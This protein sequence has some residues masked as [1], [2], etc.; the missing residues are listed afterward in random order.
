MNLN[1]HCQKYTGNTYY[2][3]RRI[4]FMTTPFANA[5]F[6]SNE[7]NSNAVLLLHAYTGSP[8]DVNMLARLLNRHGYNVLAP[9]FEGHREEDIF[10][11]LKARPHQW[12]A[13]TRQWLEWLNQEGYDKI[14]VFGL[15]MGGVFAT[16]AMTQEEFNIVSGGVF[17]SPVVTKH[18]INIERPFM[19]YAKL[20]YQDAGYDDFDQVSQEIVEKHR[21]Q[22]QS[23]ETFKSD[24]L[25]DLS[26]IQQPFYIA[27]SGQDELINPDDAKN[28]V[29]ALSQAKVYFHEYPN[30]THVITVNRQRQEFEED[31]LNFLDL[32]NKG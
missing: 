25:S 15:S 26:N 18:P 9:L 11:F 7:E 2:V 19:H 22:I 6:Y 17:N 20:V 32:T 8:M 5:K 16:W 10:T 12:Q 14:S 29:E 27:Q 4:I 28:L 24:W 31:V 30:S 21:E 13:Q 23:L 3:Y 1:K